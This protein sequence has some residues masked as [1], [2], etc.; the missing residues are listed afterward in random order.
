[1]LQSNDHLDSSSGS[2]R[3]NV[4]FAGEY[5][6]GYQARIAGSSESW[7]ATACWQAGWQ[8]ADRELT[9]SGRCLTSSLFDGSTGSD[10]TES[11]LFG[12]GE[13]ARN[14]ELPFDRTFGDSW[15]RSW[16]RRDIELECLH[17]RTPIGEASAP[18]LAALPLRQSAN[19]CARLC[20]PTCYTLRRQD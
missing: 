5:E 18:A 7:T 4:W 13:L 9:A 17:G 20:V 12:T 14:Y 16:I 2:S 11:S 8:E 10:A 1:M 6:A 19:S 3:L 15:K